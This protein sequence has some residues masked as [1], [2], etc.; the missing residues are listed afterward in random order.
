MRLEG[1]SKLLVRPLDLTDRINLELFERHLRQLI[2]PE[3]RRL[4]PERLFHGQVIVQEAPC[5]HPRRIGIL[6]LQ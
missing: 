1:K 4:L 3:S 6:V 5:K 2:G